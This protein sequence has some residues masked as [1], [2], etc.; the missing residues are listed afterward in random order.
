ML[1]FSVYICFQQWGYD[2]GL[3][4]S[5]QGAFGNVRTVFGC[6]NDWG[7]FLAFR[8]RVQNGKC[9]KKNRTALH[10]QW[11]S[12]PECLNVLVEKPWAW[13]VIFLPFALLFSIYWW[14]CHIGGIRCCRKSRGLGVQYIWVWVLLLNQPSCVPEQIICFLYA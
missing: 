11:L 7:M 12:C 5:A 9:P 1:C 6:H 3:Y 13:C 2:G 14:H 4:C 8:D 10:K